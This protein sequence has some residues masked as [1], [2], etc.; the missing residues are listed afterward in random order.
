MVGVGGGW[1]GRTN[2]QTVCTQTL[3]TVI[4]GSQVTLGFDVWTGPTTISVSG[5]TVNEHLIWG[6]ET[7]GQPHRLCDSLFFC[8]DA[9]P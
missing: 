6:N 3:K 7:I 1:G 5:F 9:I 8:L 4:Q 2:S